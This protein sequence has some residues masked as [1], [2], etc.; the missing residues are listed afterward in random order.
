MENNP[1]KVNKKDIFYRVRV[2]GD[3]VSLS[4]MPRNM[5][6]E[7]TKM[8]RWKSITYH[9]KPAKEMYTSD[10]EKATAMYW[11]NAENFTES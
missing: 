4:C 3:H 1:I 5:V 8:N 6:P 11:E 2:F 9:E 7:N 10:S